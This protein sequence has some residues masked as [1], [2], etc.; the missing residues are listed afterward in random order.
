MESKWYRIH[1]T[2][3][4]PTPNL[5]VVRSNY[6]HT[7]SRFIGNKSDA[8][9][10]LTANKQLLIKEIKRMVSEKE[11]LT[12]VGPETAALLKGGNVWKKLLAKQSAR[13]KSTRSASASA[14]LKI[15]KLYHGKL[16]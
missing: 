3:S 15:A 13:R 11:D 8:Q 5:G 2:V 14:T 12:H 16:V 9:Q 10:V 4:R 1:T 6:Y 7:K